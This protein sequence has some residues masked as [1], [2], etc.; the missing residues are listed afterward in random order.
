[1]DR[2]QWLSLFV[3]TMPF[4]LQLGRC[5]DLPMY[6]AEAIAIQQVNTRSEGVFMGM[7]DRWA[8]SEWFMNLI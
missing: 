3:Q 6:A 2:L 4:V 8:V 5:Q 7:I 1:M